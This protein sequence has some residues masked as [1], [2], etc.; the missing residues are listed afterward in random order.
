M[1]QHV[2]VYFFAAMCALDVVTGQYIFPDRHW[3]DTD[4]KRI[5]AH[6][7]GLLLAPTDGRWYWYGESKKLDDSKDPKKCKTQGVRRCVASF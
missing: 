4:G 5:E 7:A 1:C 2:L 3:N 6:A